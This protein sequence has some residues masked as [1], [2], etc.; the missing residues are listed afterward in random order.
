MANVPWPSGVPQSGLIGFTGGPQPNVSSFKPENGPSIDRRRGSS[1][2][3]KRR[4]TLP[5]MTKTQYGVFKAFVE[6]DLGD[7]VLPFDWH[8]ALTNATVRMKFV[9]NDPLYEE[10]LTTTELIEISF[11]VQIY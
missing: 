10:R 6:D 1:K 7:G 9:H 4:I 2:V 3:R 5:P 11:E 8:D